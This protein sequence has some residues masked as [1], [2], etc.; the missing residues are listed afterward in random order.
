MPGISFHVKR[1]ISSPEKAREIHEAL[2][3]IHGLPFFTQ[4]IHGKVRKL[5]HNVPTAIFIGYTLNGR[6]GVIDALNHLKDDMIYNKLFYNMKIQRER[7]A[8]RREAGGRSE[9]AGMLEEA[10]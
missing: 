10:S 9:E 1:S 3:N 7:E 2:D 8:K 6:K 5:T 4:K